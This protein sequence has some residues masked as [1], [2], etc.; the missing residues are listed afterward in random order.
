MLEEEERTCSSK[1]GKQRMARVRQAWRVTEEG[2]Q[3]S[4]L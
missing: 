2:H 1:V 4:H 3:H